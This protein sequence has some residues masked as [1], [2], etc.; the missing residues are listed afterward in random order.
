MIQ[1]LTPI[2][3]INRWSKIASH[4]PRRTDNEIKNY[5]NSKLRKKL[6]EKGI[7][8][9]THMPKSDQNFLDILS[10]VLKISPQDLGA[11]ISS[12]SS[13]PTKTMP[14]NTHNTNNNT[15]TCSSSQGLCQVTNYVEPNQAIMVDHKNDCTLESCSSLAL[16]DYGLPNSSEA[17]STVNQIGCNINYDTTNGSSAL[18]STTGHVFENRGS[19]LLDDIETTDFW[20]DIFTNVSIF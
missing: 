10:Q 4:L 12:S 13:L 18:T 16:D 14:S 1:K 3:L 2:F 11:L 17:A 6:I 7:D 8:P 9:V 15:V 5:W 20:K 19:I